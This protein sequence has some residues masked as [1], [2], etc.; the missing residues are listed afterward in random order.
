MR[1][2]VCGGRKYAD[3]TRVEKTLQ[4][5]IS[6]KGDTPKVMTGG[7]TGADQL[8]YDWCL[9][10]KVTVYKYPANWTDLSHPDA[11]IRTRSDGTQYDALAGL[12]RNQQML[13]EKPDLVIAFPGGTGTADM[14]NRARKAGVAVINLMGENN[15]D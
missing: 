4:R 6:T 5:L 14:V 8:A 11:V 12:R 9:A 1:V 13:D 3:K 7:A 15:G 10:N 2:I